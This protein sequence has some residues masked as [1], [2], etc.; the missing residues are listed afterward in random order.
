M[1]LASML[2]ISSGVIRHPGEVNLAP[3]VVLGA[4][5]LMA[6]DIGLPASD[7]LAVE[8][9]FFGSIGGRSLGLQGIQRGFRGCVHDSTPQV[10][11]I[12]PSLAFFLSDP[13][14]VAACE[15]GENCYPRAHDD[16]ALRG[17]LRTFLVG[18]NRG[19]SSGIG[20]LI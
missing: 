18:P 13:R 8:S 14:V 4:I 9:D 16:H 12:A 1:I 17:H 15:L 19:V 5:L 3:S 20:T 6:D 2:G 7:K 11:R 10:H